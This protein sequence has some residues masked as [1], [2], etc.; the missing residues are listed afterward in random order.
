MGNRELQEYFE[1]FDEIPFLPMMASY[2]DDIYQ[3]LL[4]IA[5]LRGTPLT[6]EEINNAYENKVDVVKEEEKPNENEDNDMEANK[7]RNLLKR[8]GADDKEIENFMTDLYEA[9]DENEDAEE[10]DFNY[11]DSD[12]MSKLKLTEEGKDLIM[13]APKMAKDE[14]K[15]AIKE[16]LAK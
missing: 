2:E 5:L 13:N 15:K 12:T 10:D 4:S 1:K 16:Y 3:Y 9:K 6:E 14:L 11:L 7:I 8:Y